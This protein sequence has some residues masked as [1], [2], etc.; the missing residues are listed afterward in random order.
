MRGLF[1]FII[2]FISSSFCFGIS[3]GDLS[4]TERDSIIQLLHENNP[5]DL[6]RARK[7]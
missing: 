5:D 4:L 3:D 7:S 6:Q 1:V 2:L